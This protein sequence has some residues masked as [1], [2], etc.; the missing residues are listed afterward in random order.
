M[1]EA[2]KTKR[3]KKDKKFPEIKRLIRGTSQFT[4]V[5]S[6]KELRSTWISCA[7]AAS[8]LFFILCRFFAGVQLEDSSRLQHV[9]NK[10][11]YHFSCSGGMIVFFFLQYSPP[12][13]QSSGGAAI[14][15]KNNSPWPSVYSLQLELCWTSHRRSKRKRPPRA[16]TVERDVGAPCDIIKVGILSC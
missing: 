1:L 10:D 9:P 11:N 3:Q 8:T 16:E 7:P 5:W 14:L 15:L 12:P 6:V 13:A 4:C 2:P